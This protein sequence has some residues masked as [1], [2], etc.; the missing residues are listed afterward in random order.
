MA[1]ERITKEADEA[2]NNDPLEL[3]KK[4]SIL[5][6]LAP[7]GGNNFKDTNQAA[8]ISE[9]IAR[10]SPESLI[11]LPLGEITLSSVLTAKKS[12]D[13]KEKSSPLTS[14]EKT[15]QHNFQ[16]RIDLEIEQAKGQLRGVV[17]RY[18]EHADQWT[19]VL[20]HTRSGK[21]TEALSTAIQTIET[22]EDVR[23]TI[24][25]SL[26][27]KDGFGEHSLNTMLLD[28]V[29]QLPFIRYARNKKANI[30]KLIIK[31]RC[32]GF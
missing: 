16:R 1:W 26:V 31:M 22:I 18:E 8:K 25:G 9:R 24:V 6:F 13:E 11:M 4:I 20:A 32:R 23:K 2:K 21:K 17:S 3:K 7:V 5:A 28:A 10:L 19:R 29:Q 15:A 27:A 12:L 14:D 30:K